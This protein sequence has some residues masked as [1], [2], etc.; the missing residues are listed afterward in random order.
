[1]YPVTAIWLVLFSF[2]SAKFHFVENTKQN[3]MRGRG[4]LFQ[5]AY[6]LLRICYIGASIH[7]SIICIIFLSIVN[8]LKQKSVRETVIVARNSNQAYSFTHENT[9][10]I[11]LAFLI[12]L[13][14]SLFFPF[15]FYLS[16]PLY[17]SV[18]VFWSLM[19]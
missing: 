13:S 5:T 2:Q 9:S 3:R 14:H 15:F 4:N 19:I 1:M 10:P 12:S 18:I 16:V 7:L 17:A 8:R 11:S 6:F